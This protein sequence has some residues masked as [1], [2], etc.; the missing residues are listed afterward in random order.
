MQAIQLNLSDGS[1]SQTIQ[2]DINDGCIQL[3]I[4]DDVTCVQLKD[5]PKYVDDA[6]ALADGLVS[7]DAYIV[8]PGNDTLAENTIKLVD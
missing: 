4:S 3:N 7:G 5:L 2:L 8:G 1:I 6:A